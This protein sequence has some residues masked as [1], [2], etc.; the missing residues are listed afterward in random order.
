VGRVSLSGKRALIVDDNRA[1]LDIL[2]HML[3]SAGMRVMCLSGGERIVPTLKTAFDEKDPF[4]I[5]ILDIL[6]GETSGIEVAEKI[7][8]LNP[9]LS[10][11]PLIAFSSSI[12]KNAKKCRDAGFDGFLPKPI[13]REK[14]YR[15]MEQL[16]GDTRPYDFRYPDKSSGEILTQY[17]LKEKVK[18]SVK[19]LLAEDNPTN[20][21]LAVILLE[22]AGYCV[23]VANNGKEALGKYT[24]SPLRF[25]LI[26]M[27]IQMPEMDGLESTRAIR[28]FETALKAGAEIKAHIPIVAMTA[29]AIKGDR[30]ICLEAGMDDYVAKPIQRELVYEI[31]EKYMLE[32]S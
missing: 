1:N 18:H 6:M 4:S 16:L 3:V 15:M 28:K 17:S 25:D 19:I 9:Q 24:T 21:K 22:K 7:R 8:K 27:D 23:E 31:I 13:R 10:H 2:K 20:Q 30:E 11:L 32:K 26:F 14:L 5:C 29:N 12:E